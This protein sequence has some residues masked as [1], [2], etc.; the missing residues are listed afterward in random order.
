MSVQNSHAEVF[1]RTCL[2]TPVR[3]E[4]LPAYNNLLHILSTQVICVVMELHY[5]ILVSSL[6]IAVSYWKCSLLCSRRIRPRYKIDNCSSSRLTPFSTYLG[7][8]EVC[9]CA[10]A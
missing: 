1:S 6:S 8:L 9:V 3:K 7:M 5:L 4:S 10:R 2:D